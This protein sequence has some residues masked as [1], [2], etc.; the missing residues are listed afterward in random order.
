M[1]AT[2]A[3]TC[4]QSMKPE[5]APVQPRAGNKKEQYQHNVIGTTKWEH[6]EQETKPR[7]TQNWHSFSNFIPAALQHTH[8]SKGLHIELAC[9]SRARDRYT[10]A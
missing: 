3:S 1:T 7:A 8:N 9:T 6:T 4:Q 2:S 5:A 10:R